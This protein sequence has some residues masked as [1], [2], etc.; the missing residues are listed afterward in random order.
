[1]GWKGEQSMMLPI[2][3]CLLSSKVYGVLLYSDKLL[4][5]VQVVAG[6]HT[7]M[8]YRKSI[9]IIWQR[10]L[11]MRAVNLLL[12]LWPTVTF[13][14]EPVS[15]PVCRAEN[16]QAEK[17]VRRIY[18]FFFFFFLLLKLL[19]YFFSWQL[20]AGLHMGEEQFSNVPSVQAPCFLLLQWIAWAPYSVVL[21]LS[22]S[23]SF[24]SQY[25]LYLLP[26]FYLI[27]KHSHCTETFW[28]SPFIT[29]SSVSILHHSLH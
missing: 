18:Y 17:V 2:A 27:D 3:C 19:M 13:N 22:L 24:V 20:L 12:E 9:P 23:R 28:C 11:A 29:N 10:L 7:V 1:M 26:C 14:T 6:W 15:L 8:M 21:K 5:S 25:V 4:G 16:S